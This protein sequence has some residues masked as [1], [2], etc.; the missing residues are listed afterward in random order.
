MTWF[1]DLSIRTKFLIPFVLL[2]LL[3]A[4][5]G[6]MGNKVLVIGT[7]LLGTALVVVYSGNISR[8]LKAI[9][10]FAEKTAVGSIDESAD[11]DTNAEF[12]KLGISLRKIQQR[13]K[14]QDRIASRISQ[15]NLT[16]EVEEDRDSDIFFKSMKHCIET[17]QLL[18]QEILRLTAAIDSGMLSERCNPDRFQGVY[19]SMMHNI[20]HMM[21]AVIR[22]VRKSLNVLEKVANRDLTSRL[23][24]S[25]SGD[26]A[27]FQTVLNSTIQTLDDALDHVSLAAEQVSSAS[28]HISEGSQVLSHE[29]SQQASSIEQVSSSLHEVSAMS[30]Q[31]SE[32]AKE[33]RDLSQGAVSAVE[34]GV[35][36]M[37]RLSEAMDRIKASSD[38]TAKII[39]TID[40]IAFQT[41]L[42]ALNA[43]VE[44]ARAGDAGKGFAVVAEEV[45]NLAMRSADAAKNTANLI[46]ESVTNSENGVALNQEVLNNLNKIS[47]QVKKVGAVMSEIVAASEQQTQGIDQVNIVINQMNL[48]TQQIAAN[49][50]ESASSAEELSGQ[51]EELKRMV[52]TFQLSGTRS[53]PAPSLGSYS[54]GKTG[55]QRAT[56]RR[57]AGAT[58]QKE[59]AQ[60]KPPDADSQNFTA[61]KAAQ[62]IPF[63]E[64]NDQMGLA[65]F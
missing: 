12:G 14:E 39:K 43:A 11:I 26:H 29:S 16:I 1:N 2:V 15:G 6:C 38:S 22:P 23:T 4:I 63:D 36:S 30:R 64:N 42:L 31:N 62:L 51:A 18:D 58:N 54:R 28:T 60:L 24:G 25:Y 53:R 50:E 34:D 40:E 13:R 8:Q 57:E 37:H 56:G 9:A 61:A 49:S 19:A 10:D 46:E 65:K 41:N 21:E 48:S 45:R 17:F 55:L 20:N 33:V 44:A 35:Q 47:S 27:T 3:S 52:R 7:L 5:F 59:D 32:N